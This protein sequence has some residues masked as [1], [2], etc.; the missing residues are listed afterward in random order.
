MS[1]NRQAVVILRQI[2]E[3]CEPPATVPVAD[4]SNGGR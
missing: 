3:V 1:D 2:N 4:Y